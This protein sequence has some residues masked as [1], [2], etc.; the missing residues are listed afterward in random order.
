MAKEYFSHDY[1]TRLDKRIKPL[2]IKHGYEGYGVFWAIVEDLYNNK[3]SLPLDYEGIAFDYRVSADL[4]KSVINDFDL[5]T[6]KDKNF[7]SSSVKKRLKEREEKS[8]KARKSALARYSKDANAVRTQSERLQGGMLLNKRKVKESKGKEIKE[9]EIKVNESKEVNTDPL[10]KKIFDEVENSFSARFF[11]I[12]V[13]LCETPK[14]RKKER[15]A[16]ELSLKKL[17]NYHEEF[18]ISLMEAAI[19]GG[20]Q[21]VVFA[22]TDEKYEKWLSN[23][24]KNGEQGNTNYRKQPAPDLQSGLNTIDAMYRKLNNGG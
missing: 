1:N 9:K 4:V 19:S 7:F 22:D 12:W 15:S 13:A 20:Y 24:N 3:N 14:W 16:L 5:F 6:I 21:G 8:E 2:L 18:A 17:N 11:E 10:S 23:R